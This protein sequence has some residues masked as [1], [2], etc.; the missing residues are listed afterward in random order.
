MKIIDAAIGVIVLFAIAMT[1]A[2]FLTVRSPRAIGSR[3]HKISSETL[4]SVH[5]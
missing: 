5:I 1:I 4:Q 2:V 3:I